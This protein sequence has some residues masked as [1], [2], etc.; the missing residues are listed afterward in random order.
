MDDVE[1]SEDDSGIDLQRV[2]AYLYT[3]IETECKCFL[4]VLRIHQHSTLLDSM[5]AWES[6]GDATWARP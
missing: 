2:D 5:M 6:V 4:L 1:T 3:R